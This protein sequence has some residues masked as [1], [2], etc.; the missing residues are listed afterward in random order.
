LPRKLL[1]ARL[2]LEPG[3]VYLLDADGDVARLR[4]GTRS[5]GRPHKLLRLGLERAEGYLYFIDRDGDVSRA[6]LPVPR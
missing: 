4:I 5:A 2:V 3:F 1:R 6:P